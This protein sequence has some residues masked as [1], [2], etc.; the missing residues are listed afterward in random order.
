MIYTFENETPQIPQSCFVA[1][2]ATVI[3]QVTLG[4]NV[5]VWYGAVLRADAAPILIGKN[6]NVQDCAVF[7]CD[8]GFPLTLGE[9]VTVGHSA[10][11]HGATVG[12]NV[13]IGMHATL[14]NGCVIGENSIVAAGA[15]V[16]EG[17]VVPPNSLAVGVPARIIPYVNEERA[18]QNRSTA[19]HYVEMGQ[20][21][22][23]ACS[24]C[25]L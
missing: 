15:L 23:S 19:Q 7:H 22:K 25:S 1:E 3:G 16:K 18:Q 14:L 24:P 4:E 13:L 5:S 10:I 8:T 9:G 21:H 17:Q 11:V 12:D 20:R 6:S 2:N